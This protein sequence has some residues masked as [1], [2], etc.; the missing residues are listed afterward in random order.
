MTLANKVTLS[1]IL[2]I[3]VFVGCAVYYAESVGAGAPVEAYRWAAIIVFAV[4]S[5]SDALDGYLARHFHQ[6]SRLGR[7]L[8]PLADKG[9]MFSAL[10]VLSFS[11][12]PWKFPLWFPVLVIARDVILITGSSFIHHVNGHVEV[13]PHWTGKMATFFQMWAIAWVLLQW[14]LPHPMVPTVLAGV[15]TFLSGAIYLRAGMHQLHITDHAHSDENSAAHHR[16]RR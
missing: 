16:H 15:F 10:L 5:L 6:S 1:R 9:L 14:S 12:W 3:P 8:D 7:L 11:P 4:A 2:L 13:H